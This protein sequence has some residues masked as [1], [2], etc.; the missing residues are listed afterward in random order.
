MS[1]SMTPDRQGAANRRLSLVAWGTMVFISVV[2]EIAALTFAGGIPAWLPWAKMG[3]MLCLGLAALAWQP[4]RPLRDFFFVMLAFFA[5]P[6]LGGRI[7]FT[8]H[9]FQSLFGATVFDARM[10]PEQTRKLAV[11]L[12]MI[13]VLLLLGYQRRNCFLTSGNL[14]AR[15]RPVRVLGF[16]KPDP[17]PFF[18]LLWAFN[19]AAALA[20]MQYFAL[21][22][23][24]GD[25]LKVLP[26]LPSIVFYSALN[27]FNEEI[28]FRA[29][30]LA[31]LE[32]VVGGQQAL[33]L[34]AC[35]FGIA[36][37][38][39][40]PG[41]LIG[42]LASIFIGWLLGKAMLETR[43]LFWPWLIHLVSDIVI[44]VFLTMVLLK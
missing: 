20:V 18:G 22:P 35:F 13:A 9:P 4:L 16:P 14:C 21:R 17:W 8:S 31:T 29:P 25:L 33:W 27:A 2:P 1:P 3:L 37:Y 24:S 5:L 42:G 30:M 39:G 10:Q 19:V 43:G 11:S 34:S 12:G 28:T 44:F 6:V 23:T 26:I 7:D 15:I 41:G 38:F 40:T 36:H 32:P